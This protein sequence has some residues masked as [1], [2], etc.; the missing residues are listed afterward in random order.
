MIDETAL[1]NDAIPFALVT[2]IIRKRA[3]GRP[4][5]FDIINTIAYNFND[6]LPATS[7]ETGSRTTTTV[8]RNEMFGKRGEIP[9]LPRNC[10]RARCSG[11]PETVN[12]RQDPPTEAARRREGK[13]QAIGRHVPA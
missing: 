3:L 8:A 1:T 11:P 4:E 10:E 5:I 6:T 2:G 13:L 12:A 9:P 7:P